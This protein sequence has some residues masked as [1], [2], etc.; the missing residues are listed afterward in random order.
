MKI[1]HLRYVA[2][3]LSAMCFACA[4][5]PA[6]AI[7]PSASDTVY[8]SD[9][10]NGQI[11]K[12][13]GTGSSPSVFADFS[14]NFGTPYGLAADG[15]GNLYAVINYTD[16]SPDFNFVGTEIRKFSASGTSSVF[17]DG[18]DGVGEDSLGLTYHGGQ[19]F[20]GNG[21][22]ILKFDSSGAGTV[23]ASGGNLDSALGLATDSAGNVYV[24]DVTDSQILKYTS[25]GAGS[26]FASGGSLDAP[27]GLAIDGSGSVFVS[28]FGTSSILKFTSGGVE[29]VFADIGDGLDLPRGLAFDSSGSLLVAEQ[30][31]E[32][33]LQFTSGGTDSLYGNTGSGSQPFFIA[34][35]PV[36]EPSA[37]AL[38]SMAALGFS[39]VIRRR[40]MIASRR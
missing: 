10:T 8:V 26:L 17:A 21:S 37:V 5:T 29:S 18:S 11:L 32:Q 31:A 39:A 38:G 9:I 27:M 25:G 3:L 30:L 20:M 22:Q 19:L 28:N 23:F 12:F 36:P 33:V 24:N 4:T 16:G 14:A 7:P 15:G 1:F 35:V 34:V 6:M 2:P 40:R 13:T